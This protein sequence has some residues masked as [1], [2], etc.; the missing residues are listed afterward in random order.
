[1]NRSSFSPKLVL[2]VAT[3]NHFSERGYSL[4]VAIGT[5]VVLTTLLAS[6]AVVSQF[7][8]LTSSSSQ[9]S[10]EGFY[11]AEAG[12][13]LRAELVRETFDNFSSPSGNP[14]ALA[15]G[16]LP[17]IN[18]V[19]GTGDY[20]CITYDFE[21]SAART[22]LGFLGTTNIT[23]GPGEPFQFL[24]AQEFRYVSSST[25]FRNNNPNQPQAILGM[26]F[27]NR[28]VPLFQFMVFYDKDLEITP[29]SNMTLNGPIHANANVFLNDQGGTLSLTDRLTIGRYPDGTAGELYRRRKHNTNCNNNSVTVDDNNGNSLALA[30]GTN[31]NNL[32][33]AL[34]DDSRIQ[35]DLPAL[36]V[37]PAESFSVDATAP[38]WS[39]AD[40]RIVLDMTIGGGTVQVRNPNE[41]QNIPL[42]NILNA[43]CA[44]AVQGSNSFFNTR[45]NKAIDMLD[46]D[47][48]ALL[49]CVTNNSVQFGFQLD[50]QTQDGLVFY[51]TVVG[52]D[53]DIA[54]NSYGLR[55]LN[56]S[57]LQSSV[58]GAP[59][60]EGLT[61][62]TDQAAY[63]QGDYNT[64]AADWVPAAVISDSLNIL[65]NSWDDANCSGRGQAVC[66]WGDREAANTTVNSAFLSGTSTTGGVEGAL[67]TGGYN[68]GMHNFP[69]LHEI[70]TGGGFSNK[71]LTIRGSFISLQEP[72]HVNGLWLQNTGGHWYYQQP[73][74][75]WS[76]ETRFSDPSQ[77]PP[78]TPQVNYLRQE[79]FVRDFT[80]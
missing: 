74:R 11:I 76:F 23:I 17:C 72:D 38:Y 8:G 51:L 77:I 36:E 62:V 20:T 5:I 63:I 27:L 4:V 28:R 50:D 18:G 32:P 16:D 7:E 69:R 12:L 33:N 80:R 68:G 45:E 19:G 42:T 71:T 60:V 67:N 64:V 54:A 55:L 31:R 70:W 65:S 2:F 73:I 21:N 66:A 26:N 43:T 40:L 35:F 29:G 39:L 56:G 61:V 30:C 15:P 46:V 49:D 48:Q 13:N 3:G 1:M 75:N 9:A 25:S 59:T 6:Y 47:V 24:N 14:E 78:M 53:S 58:A 41:T 10:N 52:P 37:P 44:G 79:L 57:S 34:I 22:G